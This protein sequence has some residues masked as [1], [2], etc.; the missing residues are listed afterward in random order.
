MATRVVTPGVFRT[1]SQ[2]L[3]SM[4][5]IGHSG[6]VGITGAAASTLSYPSTRNRYLST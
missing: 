3:D 2:R 4:S 5:S 6:T 1:D